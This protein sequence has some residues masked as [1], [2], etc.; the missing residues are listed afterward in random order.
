MEVDERWSPIEIKKINNKHWQFPMALD[1][2][3]NNFQTLIN[4]ICN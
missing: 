4:Q 1:G 2:D 3:V